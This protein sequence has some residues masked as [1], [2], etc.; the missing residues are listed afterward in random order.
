MNDLEGLASAQVSSRL[1][2]IEERLEKLENKNL[3]IKNIDEFNKK[4]ICE[5]I[6]LSKRCEQALIE[7]NICLFI[8]IEE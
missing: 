3:R 7:A 5:N 4:V 8:D 1:N 2:F 6:C